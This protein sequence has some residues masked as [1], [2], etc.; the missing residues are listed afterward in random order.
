VYIDKGMLFSS[1]N[2]PHRVLCL[3]VFLNVLI[4]FYFDRLFW[5]PILCDTAT[6]CLNWSV[7]LPLCF[8]LF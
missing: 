7:I 5:S 1:V 4:W 3:F 2:L 8:H 6:L